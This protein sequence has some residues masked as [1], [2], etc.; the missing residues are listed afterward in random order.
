MKPGS[1]R[2]LNRNGYGLKHL[3]TVLAA[4]LIL[5]TQG[6][7]RPRGPDIPEPGAPPTAPIRV[8]APAPRGDFAVSPGTVEIYAAEAERGGVRVS[9]ADVERWRVLHAKM[10]P[11]QAV[12][13]PAAKFLL[14]EKYLES[15]RMIPGGES[16]DGAFNAK[17]NDSLFASPEEAS[18]ARKIIRFQEAFKHPEV[19]DAGDRLRDLEQ[20]RM[21]A[22]RVESPM[23]DLEMIQVNGDPSDCMAWIGLKCMVN[24]G[25]Y[26]AATLQYRVPASLPLDSARVEILRRYLPVK[27]IADSARALGMDWNSDSLAR[28]SEY[29]QTAAHWLH[30]SQ[31][32]GKPVSDPAILKSLYGSYY[33]KYFA[34][35]E[36]LTLAIIGSSDSVYLDSLYRIQSAWETSS[37]S[38]KGPRLPSA[39]EPALPWTHF[40]ESELPREFKSALYGFRIGQCAPPFRTSMGFFMARITNAART[41]ELAFREALPTLLFLATRDK[42][43]N[44]DS[45]VEAQARKYYSTH[46]ARFALPDTLEL[47]TWLAPRFH[48]A[49]DSAS[50]SGK[51]LGPMP[52]TAAFR[53]V[54]LSSLW[55]P[56]A[57][58]MR[59]QDSAKRQSRD[60]TIGPLT[61][62]F[63][64]WHFKILSRRVSADTLPFRLARKGI[65]ETLTAPAPPMER[66]KATLQGQARFF[67]DLGLADAYV[68][69]KNV[70]ADEASRESKNIPNPR[71]LP[72]P[73]PD[74]EPPK[75]V[76]VF[77]QVRLNTAKLY[78]GS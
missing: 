13:E 62:K 20:I 71:R 74:P 2:Y 17:W 59:I 72:L 32:F 10:Y 77:G 19:R 75:H 16:S 68:R 27:Q 18:Q 47:Q 54:R 44:N 34:A 31:R 60:S 66:A 63:G 9:E 36:E 22:G 65:L 50:S 14:A 3:S 51:P 12:P 78:S 39:P 56:D 30:A 46:K 25:E 76:D 26:N 35:R 4:L 11:G 64:T 57:F 8:S 53:S 15:N 6:A 69:K 42:Y 43:L 45:V 55:L 29:R 61:D 37:R 73:P 58:R 40:K 48:R 5:E 38:R 52:D 23:W 70:K 28:E 49:R 33:D 24:L 41:P 21:F 67:L 7:A 1:K